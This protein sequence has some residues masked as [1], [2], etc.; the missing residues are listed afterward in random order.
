MPPADDDFDIYGEDDGFSS[1]KVDESQ[2]DYQVQ[3]DEKSHTETTHSPV[4]GEKRL[5]DE[6]DSDQ[7]RDAPSGSAQPNSN[8]ESSPTPA[9][10]AQTGGAYNGGQANGSAGAG[11]GGGGQYDALY[12]GDL[13]WVCTFVFSLAM[14][15]VYLRRR[16]VCA[17]RP[18]SLQW[19]TDEDLRQVALNL[20][21]NVDHKDVT[22]SEH[23]VNGK[24]KG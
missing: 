21:I 24:S 20:G 14:Y 5:R 18:F 12:I 10:S 23:K 2:D 16:D 7:Q 8:S 17:L 6:D 9:P 22:F 13:Q 1:V 15:A 3:T 19:T 11:A 4:V